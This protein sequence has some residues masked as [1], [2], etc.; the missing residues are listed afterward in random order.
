MKKLIVYYSR[1][2]T[3]KKVA[4]ILSVKLKA[5]LTEL[6]D[7]QDRSGLSGYIRSGYEA[8]I[9]KERPLNPWAVICRLMI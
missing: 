8:V 3:T 6:V 4:E 2:G 9:K 7:M 5:D 1:T